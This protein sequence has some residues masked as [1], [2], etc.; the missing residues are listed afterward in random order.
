MSATEKC[1]HKLSQVNDEEILITITQSCIYFVLFAYLMKD[2]NKY[3]QNLN[4]F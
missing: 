4:Y 3:V 1:V 2:Y